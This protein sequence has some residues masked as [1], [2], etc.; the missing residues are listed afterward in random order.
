MIQDENKIQ[1]PRQLAGVGE[2]LLEVDRLIE[3]RASVSVSEYERL[4]LALKL[5]ANLIR[6]N[7]GDYRDEHMY[8]LTNALLSIRDLLSEK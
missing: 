4:T 5:Q 1:E 7:E 8:F 6:F 3:G 2:C